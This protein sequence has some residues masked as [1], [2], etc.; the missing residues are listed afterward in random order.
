MATL[1]E[2]EKVSQAVGAG[3]SKEMM[4][5]WHVAVAVVACIAAVAYGVLIETGWPLQAA[6]PPVEVPAQHE[7]RLI[8]L[9]REAI[10]AAYRQHVQSVFMTWMK[11]ATGQPDRA[12][13]GVNIARKAYV[14]AM[15]KI[16]ERQR[17]APK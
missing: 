15:G 10:E 5:A 4:K 3:S 6:I 1:F 2:A 11:D 16:E 12:V 13:R 14:D 17:A 8:E 9:D 7:V